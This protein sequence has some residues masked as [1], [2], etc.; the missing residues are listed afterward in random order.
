MRGRAWAVTVLSLVAATAAL[1]AAATRS[2]PARLGQARYV[3]LGYDLDGGAVTEREAARHPEI[4]AEDRRALVA[5]RSAMNKWNR[6][7]VVDDTARAELMLAVRTGR[8][9]TA[10]ASVPGRPLGGPGHP[11]GAADDIR[12]IASS[13]DDTLSVYEFGSGKPELLL[14]RESEA[15]GL[16]RTPPPLVGTF[17]ADVESLKQP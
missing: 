8:R 12:P 16:S 10:D 6:Y 4:L 1:A 13:P 15:E 17:R 14:W 5:V 2:L 7:V 9:G 11:Q 3:I